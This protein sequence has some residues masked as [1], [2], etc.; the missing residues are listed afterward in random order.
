MG[1]SHASIKRTDEEE[2]VEEQP[3]GHRHR[4]RGA[5]VSSGM[6]T[7]WRV[8]GAA[9]MLVAGV[10]AAVALAQKPNLTTPEGLWEDTRTGTAI[11]RASQNVPFPDVNPATSHDWPLNNYDLANSR[12]APL[13]QINTANVGS[14]A[15]RWLFHG[16]G[17]RSTPIVANGVMYLTTPS[18]VVAIDA[19]TGR[20]V[21]SNTQA[22]GTRGATYGDGT[23]YTANDVRVMALDARTGEFVQGVLV[24]R[25]SPR[26]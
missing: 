16:G 17:G 2:Y 14:L 3:G 26:C 21:W 18:S 10:L 13:D 9:L 15:V 19:A 23:I 22:S 4:Q 12:Y 8:S 11:N 20:T 5:A 25:A 6:S 1:R 7:P 24:T